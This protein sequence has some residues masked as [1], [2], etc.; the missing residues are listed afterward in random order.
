MKRFTTSGTTSRRP[1]RLS[2]FCIGSRFLI[3]CVTS[4][5]GV[6]GMASPSPLSLAPKG[7]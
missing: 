3:I 5:S 2:P 7:T 1:R 6:R 4:L